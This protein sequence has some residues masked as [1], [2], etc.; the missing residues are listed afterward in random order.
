MP[1]G[2]WGQSFEKPL[3][4]DDA[5]LADLR[6]RYH[7]RSAVTVDVDEA[8]HATRIVLPSGLTDDVRAEIEKRL[9]ELR[10]VPAECNGLRCD[11][12]LQIL[13]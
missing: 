9:R 13:I 11:G 10:Y 3:I 1:P 4:A 6:S 12:T 7:A 8:G 5:A 2:G